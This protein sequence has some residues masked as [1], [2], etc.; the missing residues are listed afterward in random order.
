MSGNSLMSFIPTQ[1]V[2]SVQFLIQILNQQL[3]APSKV[4]QQTLSLKM[5]NFPD[6]FRI[7]VMFFGVL[8]LFVLCVI[9]YANNLLCNL[10]GILYPV[11]DGLVLFNTVPVPT[12][13][14]LTLNKYWILY[15][16]L[17]MYESLFGFILRF[18]P[19]YYY[20]KFAFIYLLVRNDFYYTNTVFDFMDRRYQSL[21]IQGKITK[22]LSQFN[23]AL[24]NKNLT[25]KSDDTSDTTDQ[26]VSET[27]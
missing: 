13:K 10:I 24:D 23:N 16:G 12:N 7:P 17:V 27:N 14:L 22:F 25:Q 11:L 26:D 2:T 8:G 3:A 5:E 1:V 6:V 20:F 4:V 18:I 21:N 19:F 15:G 9:Y